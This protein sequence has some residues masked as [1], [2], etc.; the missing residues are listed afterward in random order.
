MAQSR[1]QPAC[2]VVTVRMELQTHIRG[3]AGFQRSPPK[4]RPQGRPSSRK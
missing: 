3:P 4:P 2:N 1:G